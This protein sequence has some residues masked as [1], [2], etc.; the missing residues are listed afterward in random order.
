MHFLPQGMT[1]GY[2]VARGI[3]PEAFVELSLAYS[4]G[5]ELTT[6]GEKHPRVR[7]ERLLGRNRRWCGRSRNGS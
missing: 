3:F 4:R 2:G 5:G 6:P 7:Q 1:A